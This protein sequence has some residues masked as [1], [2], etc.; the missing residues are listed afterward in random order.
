M[1][2]YHLFCEFQQNLEKD[3]RGH[4]N[5]EANGLINCYLGLAYNLYLL[6]HNAE[7]HQRYID[8]LKH[9][10]QFQGAYYELIVANC[11]IRAG[12]DLELEDEDDPRQKHCE[13]SATSIRTGKKFWVEAKARSVSGTLGKT[14][15]NG[16][17]Q[18][19]N[20]TSQLSN[21]IKN[22]L[23]KPADSDRIIFVDVNTN[24]MTPEDFQSDPPRSPK[25]MDDAERRLKD[26]EKH[27]KDGEQ[28]YIF[29]TN[30]CYHNAL[31]DV[32]PGHAAITFGLG[33][34][35]YVKPHKYTFPEAWHVKQKHID[36]F[37]LKDVITTYPQI[38]N[39][40]D[41]A[42]PPVATGERERLKIGKIYEFVDAGITGEVISAVVS[43]NEKK[44]WAVVRGQDGKSSIL[45]EGISDIE[46]EVY[47]ASRE[48]YFGAI[49]PVPK[50][51]DKPYDLFESMM[52]TYKETPK[53]KLLEW[54]KDHSDINRLKTLE[55]LDL[56]LTYCE[57][58]TLSVLTNE[59]D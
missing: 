11:M 29:V 38:P 58:I 15:K 46:L 3:D 57:R 59:R 4:F 21:H 36:M 6:E 14:D 48:T 26:K 20:P 16:Q 28:A 2:W 13:F 18:K 1:Q 40:F 9:V 17:Q 32:F 43:E 22:A 8:R 53:E 12:F 47:K 37:T 25:W 54:M 55:H 30:F 44:I 41:D 45:S 35:D 19:A 5:T 24:P 50:N 56:A 7:L 23:A 39:S 51:V 33:I 27:L 10:D 34:E 31:Y 42:L 49:Q 52:E